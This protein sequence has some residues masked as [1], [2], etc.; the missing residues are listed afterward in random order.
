MT[1]ILADAKK[2]V[3]VCDSMASYGD[4]WFPVTKVYRVGDEL[5]GWAGQYS[6]GPRWL[7]WY[8]SG[9]R[10]KMPSIGNI[11]VLILG[12]DGLRIFEPGGLST[13]IERGW[14]AV[15]S[16]AN[17][18]MGA[19]MAGADAKKAVEIACKIDSGSGGD[20]VVHRLKG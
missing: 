7:D 8:S 3:M 16:G 4:S 9:Q 6:E 15:G 11:S 12:A 13:P 14:Q 2:G 5:V 20:V 17:A 19:F 1:T 18:A 10:G